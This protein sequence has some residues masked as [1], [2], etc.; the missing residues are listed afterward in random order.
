MHGARNISRRVSAFSTCFHIQCEPVRLSWLAHS[1][2][3]VPNPKPDAGSIDPDEMYSALHDVGASISLE[4]V[5]RM[6][7]EVDDEGSGEIEFAE[8]CAIMETCVDGE[9]EYTYKVR[10]AVGWQQRTA[11]EQN[12]NR[13]TRSPRSSGYNRIKGTSETSSGRPVHKRHYRFICEGN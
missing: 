8:F 7:L 10:R 3:Y 9:P 2:I 13:R 12:T 11:L 1:P 4:E 5:E 6:I